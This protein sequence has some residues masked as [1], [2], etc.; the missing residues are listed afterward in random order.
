MGVVAAAI[1]RAY[2]YF[3]SSGECFF[4]EGATLPAER[5]VFVYKNRPDE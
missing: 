5:G 4:A 1:I 3:I 2:N